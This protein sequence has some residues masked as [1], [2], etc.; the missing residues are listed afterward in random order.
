MQILLN[1]A[2]EAELS[3]FVGATHVRKKASS[4][5][6]IV[7]GAPFHIT[8]N[9]STTTIPERDGILTIPLVLDGQ[10][11]VAVQPIGINQ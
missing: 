6:D 3:I 11:Q 1:G 4:P 7:D 10:A 8:V 2:G 9:G 5:R